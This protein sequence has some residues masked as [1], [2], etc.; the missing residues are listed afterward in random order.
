MCDGIVIINDLSKRLFKEGEI[1]R[2]VNRNEYIEQSLDVGM[3]GDMFSRF[4]KITSV[5]PT[6]SGTY[7]YL[8]D[9]SFHYTNNMLY[10]NRCKSCNKLCSRRK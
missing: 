5:I 7:A 4:L 1:V 6:E 2:S 8:C 9:D 3:Y 10:Y